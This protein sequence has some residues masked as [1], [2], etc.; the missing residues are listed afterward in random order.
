M[1]IHW[2]QSPTIPIG[3]SRHTGC[4]C[5]GDSSLQ[6]MCRRGDSNPHEGCPSTDFKSVAST[7]P[8]RRHSC[9]PRSKRQ[10]HARRP[11]SLFIVPQYAASK[12]NKCP[13]IRFALKNIPFT[14]IISPTQF[15]GGVVEWSIAPVLKTGG[16]QGPVGS[17]P[18]PSAPVILN[19]R[20]V[21]P[22]RCIYPQRGWD[23]NPFRSE[24]EEWV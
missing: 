23:E 5:C 4:G 13:I 22:L 21:S 18:T 16:P 17:N 1:P 8:P 6:C 2:L 15:I 9:A 10:H 20:G 24:A 19:Q 3:R 11:A 14:P 7:I 12:T